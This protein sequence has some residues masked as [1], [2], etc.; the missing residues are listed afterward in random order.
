MACDARLSEQRRG[1]V[2]AVTGHALDISHA[3]MPDSGILAP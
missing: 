1:L 3:C 2:E